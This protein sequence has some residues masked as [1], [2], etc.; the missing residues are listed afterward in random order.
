[1]GAPVASKEPHYIPLKDSIK[2]QP[3]IGP[4]EDTLS[5]LK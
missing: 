3:F 5:E 2:H 1:M 4:P